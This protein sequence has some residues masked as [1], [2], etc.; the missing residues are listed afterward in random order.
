MKPSTDLSHA[1]L[2]GWFYLQFDHSTD[3]TVVYDEGPT[4][5]GASE[6][7]L[8]L[9]WQKQSGRVADPVTVTLELPAGWRLKAAATGAPEGP[10]AVIATDLGVDRLFHFVYQ[11]G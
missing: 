1:V 4:V 6:H 8:Q 11:G 5:T 9:L 2:E 10:R 3:I 7:M